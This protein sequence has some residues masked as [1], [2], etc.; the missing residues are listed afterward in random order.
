MLLRSSK[1]KL[2]R[3]PST[4][5]DKLLSDR[6]LASL[7]NCSWSLSGPQYPKPL[8]KGDLQ[9]RYCYPRGKTEYSNGRGKLEALFVVSLFIITI[10]LTYFRLLLQVEPCGL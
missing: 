10:N 3:V 7:P 2:A 9:Q 5:S 8:N 4:L 1:S 6:D